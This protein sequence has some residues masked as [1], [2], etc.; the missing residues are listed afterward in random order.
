MSRIDRGGCS[1][2]NWQKI[3][4]ALDLEGFV[5]AHFVSR[6]CFAETAIKEWRPDEIGELDIVWMD[7]RVE[8]PTATLLDCEEEDLAE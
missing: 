2:R 5:A 7:Y 6:G 8:P 4:K 1:W 3:R